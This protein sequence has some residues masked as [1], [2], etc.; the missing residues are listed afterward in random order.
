MS[1][2][3]KTLRKATLMSVPWR[4]TG[5]VDVNTLQRECVCHCK[6]SDVG[7]VSI[8]QVR[9]N[10][11]GSSSTKEIM[12]EWKH[13]VSQGMNRT[14]IRRRLDAALARLSGS[15]PSPG[16]PPPANSADSTSPQ[17]ESRRLGESVTVGSL[18][19]P[20]VDFISE[21]RSTVGI[22]ILSFQ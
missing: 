18:L 10:A 1:R 21:N 11:S 7:S 2:R 3:H 17:S 13:R 9:L 4:S 12:E 8:D 20:E 19:S 22:C 16:D 15:S 14:P 5:L 6:A